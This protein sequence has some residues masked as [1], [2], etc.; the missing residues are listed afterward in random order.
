MPISGLTNTPKAFME[1]GRIKKGEMKEFKRQDG[2]TGTKPVDLDYF[3]F[4]FREGQNS[5]EIEKGIRLSYGNRPT[6]LNVR[7]AYH[8]VQEV[9][10]ANYECYKQGGLIAKAGVRD[11]GPYWIFYRHP[12]TSE[13]L[14]RDGSPVGP[15]GRDFF[16]RP[17][18]VTT[19]IYKNAKGEPV[20]MEPVGRLQVVIPE[21][22]HLAVGY[23]T[24]QPGSPRDIRN[25]SA[26]L[27]AYDA[28]AR[29][30][31]KTIAGIPFKLIR[32]KE[33]VTVNI[34]GKLSKKDSWV[35][36]IEVG[37]EW[38]RQ[39]IEAIERLA[40]PEYIDAVAEDVTEPVEAEELPPMEVALALA[41]GN[42]QEA[43]YETARKFVVM[44]RGKEK[45][46]DELTDEQLVYAS[47]HGKPEQ[48]AAAK[49]V[50]D[51][52]SQEAK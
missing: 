22:A 42:E 20:C 17:F 34:N 33:E 36:H 4:T 16:E 40:L 8:N 51:H 5:S 7:F 12:E 6:E 18:D 46:L 23:F 10:D 28:I 45:F 38:G 29:Q 25:I 15:E 31:G 19:P 47:T 1:L 43:D 11:T 14:V 50:L 2:S 21:V 24:F 32:R 48:Q 52:R 37:G 13:V 26:E 30:Y 44:V 39:A 27:G 41:S 3:R 9:W 49:V 35:V